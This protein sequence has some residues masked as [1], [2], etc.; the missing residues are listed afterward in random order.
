MKRLSIQL[1]L[2]I[3]RALFLAIDL[4]TT[5]SHANQY[6]VRKKIYLGAAI[7]SLSVL[8]TSCSSS[9]EKA[10]NSKK[11]TLAEINSLCYKPVAPAVNGKGAIN[12]LPK[13][14]KQP[15]SLR[16]FIPKDMI[17]ETV[18]CYDV[19]VEG[20]ATV[21]IEGDTLTFV[22]EMPSFKGGIDSM[23]RFFAKHLKYP[24]GSEDIDVAGKVIVQFVVTKTGAVVKPRVLHSLHPLFDEEALRVVKLM[25]DWNP[26]MHNGEEQNVRFIIPVIF[27]LK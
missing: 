11:D 2:F 27:Q 12:S 26:G 1:R 19:I 17:I 8:L 7:V 22:D 18:M 15:A 24:K 3:L 14:T 4:L 21:P 5:I 25:P 6:L 9:A 23:Q 13:K 16:K 10:K 20:P